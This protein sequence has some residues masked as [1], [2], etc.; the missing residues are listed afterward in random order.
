MV[1][2][3]EV[4]GFHKIWR[5]AIGARLSPEA[6][7]FVSRPSSASAPSLKPDSYRPW[8][9]AYRLKARFISTGVAQPS[10]A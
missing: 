6:G 2:N 1:V 10:F 5:G 8:P 9:V 7:G 3:Q 4:G